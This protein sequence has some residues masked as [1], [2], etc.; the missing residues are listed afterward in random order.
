MFNQHKIN[1]PKLQYFI[2][3]KGIGMVQHCSIVIQTAIESGNVKF[4]DKII[5]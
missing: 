2:D 3:L 4:D 5:N 1:I